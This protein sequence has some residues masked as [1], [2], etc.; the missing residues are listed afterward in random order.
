MTRVAT[1]MREHIIAMTRVLQK[2]RCHADF[3]DV[4][5]RASRVD[6]LKKIKNI[7]VARVSHEPILRT[8]TAQKY[9]YTDTF[10]TPLT[11]LPHASLER[12]T[13]ESHKP[14]RMR[15]VS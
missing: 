3:F 5:D 11:R 4:E 9:F 7:V 15:D 1:R 13:R 10:K 14:I 2:Y 12:K 8:R 6:A